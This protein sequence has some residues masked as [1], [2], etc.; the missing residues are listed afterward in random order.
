M[1]MLATHGILVPVPL[2]SKTGDFLVTCGSQS[3]KP[4]VFSLLSWLPGEAFGQ[5]ALP[6]RFEGAQRA[7]VMSEIGRNLAR[8]HKLSDDWVPPPAFT[9]P[10]WDHD[11]ILGEKPFWGRFWEVGFVSDSGRKDLLMLRATCRAALSRYEAD[12]PSTGLIHA[13]L[14]RE[15]ILINGAQVSFIDFDDSGFGYRLFD[16]A[17]ALIKNIYEHDYEKLKQALLRGYQDE[18]S[19][20]LTDVDAL[21]L[22]MLLRSLT[23][24]GWVDKRIAE[25]GMTEKAR[26]FLADVKYLAEAYQR[27]SPTHL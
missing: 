18:R 2:R 15:N 23:Y 25:P 11:G 26:R 14:A 17:T 7:A 8:L 20:R 27:Q 10:A 12:A 6:L 13:D 9:R 19:L 4:H 5:S 3:K 22:F 16:L 24:L 1:E 21:P